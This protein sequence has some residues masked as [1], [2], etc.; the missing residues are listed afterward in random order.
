MKDLHELPKLKESIS[1]I[2]IEKAIIE[3]DNSSITLIQGTSRTPIPISVLTCL[4]I[5]PGT[6][7]THAAI[8]AICDNGCMVVWCGD[9]LSKFYAF[10]TGETRS[11]E[12]LLHQAKMCMNEDSHLK[13]VRRMYEFRF[14]GK[15]ADDLKLQQIR[16]ME[17][18]RVKQA[19]KYASKVTGVKWTGRNYTRKDW[20]SADPINKAL[21]SAN[22]MLY[23]LCH[24]VII[25]LGYSPALSF[26]HTGKMLSFVYD[27]ADLYKA[28]TVIPAAFEAVA[29]RPFDLERRV[30]EKCRV[31]FSA[32]HLLKRIAVDI[33]W[34]LLSEEAS[35]DINKELPGDLWDDEQEAVIGGVNYD[36]RQ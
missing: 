36:G 26:I 29:E 28:E 20:D 30:R 25:S 14:P 19:Y 11:S 32:I 8:K 17:G 15:L 24:S 22:S 3:Q 21:S 33:A 7:I 4:L 5:G 1:Y 13:V 16:G 23:S 35:A 12:R 6:S 34:V 10:G 27:I 18:I 9:D 2:Y 31:R